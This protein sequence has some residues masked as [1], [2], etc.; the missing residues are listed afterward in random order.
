MSKR[1]GIV[2]A[3]MAAMLAAING[4]ACAEDLAAVAQAAISHYRAEHGLPPVTVDPR[5][6][7]LAAEQARAMA[8]ADSLEHDVDRPFQVR[9]ASYDPDIAVENIAGGTRDFTSTLVLWEHSAGHDANLRRDG[10]TRFGIASAPAPQSKY[11]VF[12]SLIMAG[13]KPH[14]GL[15]TAG[16]PGLLRAAPDQG[17]VVRVRAVRAEHAVADSPGLLATVKGWLKPLWSGS[18]SAK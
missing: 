18:S 7:A 9:V 10:V 3:L 17:P 4:V 13:T 8:K 5:L 15:R 16:G 2:A 14:H 11:K 12:W 6:M 1:A